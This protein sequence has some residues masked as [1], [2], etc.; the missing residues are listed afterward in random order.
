MQ[1]CRKILSGRLQ[2]EDCQAI[3]ILDFEM[4]RLQIQNG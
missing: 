1:L 3:Y 2:E 4:V